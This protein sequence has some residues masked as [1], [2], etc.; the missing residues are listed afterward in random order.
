MGISVASGPIMSNSD[1]GNGGDT[2]RGCV[3][4]ESSGSTS[5]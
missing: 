1:G 2:K 3:G 4:G 5:K